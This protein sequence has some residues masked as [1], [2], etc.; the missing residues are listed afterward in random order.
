MAPHLSIAY[1]WC[2]CSAELISMGSDTSQTSLGC[3]MLTKLFVL[4]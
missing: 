2:L 1:L 3:F 4:L